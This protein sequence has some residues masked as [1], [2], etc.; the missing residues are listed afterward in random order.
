M[1]TDF[2]VPLIQTPTKPNTGF[3]KEKQKH[4]DTS[5]SSS[6]RLIAGVSASIA[7]VV[8][9]IAVVVLYGRRKSR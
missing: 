7:T 1:K 8:L 3:T 6:L 9:V 5:S 4:G 2:V